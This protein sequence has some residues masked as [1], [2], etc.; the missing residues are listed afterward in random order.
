MFGFMS[1]YRVDFQTEEP[2]G[3]YFEHLKS[4]TCLIAAAKVIFLRITYRPN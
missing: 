1:R 4:A 2:V 3:F